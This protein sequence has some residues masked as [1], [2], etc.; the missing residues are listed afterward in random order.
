MVTLPLGSEFA[1]AKVR[2]QAE[3]SVPPS[4]VAPVRLIGGPV[5][6]AITTTVV[7]A[8]AHAVV[9]NLKIVCFTVFLNLFWCGMVRP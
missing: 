3:Q 9:N 4:T 2:W 6:N 8:A 1:G 5:L 7:A